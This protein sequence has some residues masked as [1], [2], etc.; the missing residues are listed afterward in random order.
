MRLNADIESCLFQ[1]VVLLLP[2]HAV[3]W[4]LSA[5]SAERHHNGCV[6]QSKHGLMPTITLRN[7]PPHLH[8]RLKERAARHRRSINSELIHIIEQA[9]EGSSTPAQILE[10]VQALRERTPA[11]TLEPD[12]SKREAREDLE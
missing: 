3:E 6:V 5:R 2:I 11:Y 8:E 12:E 10:R 4:E 9:V 7:L 1:P